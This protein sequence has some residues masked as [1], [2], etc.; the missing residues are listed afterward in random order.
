MCG[1]VGLIGSESPVEE[2]HDGLLRDPAPGSGR[3]GH[4]DLRRAVPRRKGEGLVAK[5]FR[6]R[7]CAAVGGEL[8]LG[9]VRYPTIGSGGVEDAQPF[10]VTAPLRHR[11][12]PTRQCLELRRGAAAPPDPGPAAPASRSVDVEANSQRVRRRAGE[13]MRRRPVQRGDLPRRRGRSLRPR[14]AA[15]TPW[16]ASWPEKGC[17]AFRDPTASSRSASVA[18]CAPTAGSSTR[19]VRERRCSEGLGYEVEARRGPV[20]PCSCVTMG[21]SCGT[22]SS[23]RCFARAFSNSSTSLAPTSN[24]SDGNERLTVRASAWAARWRGRS[25]GGGS[26]R[27]HRARS[28]ILARRGAR[29]GPRAGVVVSRSAGQENRTSGG[30]SSCPRRR[31][32]GSRSGTSS[33]S[34]PP[35]CAA[36]R[37]CSWMTPSSAARRRGRSSRCCARPAPLPCT[38]PARRPAASP[39]RLRDRHVHAPRVRRPRTGPRRRSLNCSGGQR[40]LPGPRGLVQSVREESPGQ[41]EDTCHACFSGLYPTG[42]VAAEALQEIEDERLRNSSQT[43]KAT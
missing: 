23:R 37:F 14:C 41:L 12:G 15:P 7:S 21:R 3:G 38:S 40:D 6:P 42:D 24:A 1:F 22:R 27:H 11:H 9:T 25:A 18:A 10:V 35:K 20:K 32:A 36:V 16:S 13:T 30:P 2:I 33:M 5:C 8:A 29:N 26:R 43:D 17:F 39:V 31:T 4:R 28:G 34:S 19:G